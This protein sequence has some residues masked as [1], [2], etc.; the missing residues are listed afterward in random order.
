M[1]IKIIFCNIWQKKNYFWALGSPWA[2]LQCPQ[3]FFHQKH[4]S[5]Q[6]N[7][8]YKSKK[9]IFTVIKIILCNIWPKQNYFWVL[10]TPGHPY[11][12]PQF[13]FHI[14]NLFLHLITANT[15]KKK[16]I[17]SDQN[18]TLQYLAKKCYFWAVGTPWAP[19]QCP[20]FF[21]IKNMFL[22]LITVNTST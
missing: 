19:L 17:Y 2:P 12:A 1:V 21:L 7:S 13:F 20:P 14:K 10:G 11:S 9:T 8:Q 3:F 4:A 18:H 16:H 6:N 15:S 22:L 5:A